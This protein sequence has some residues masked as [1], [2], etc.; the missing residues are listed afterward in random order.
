MKKLWLEATQGPWDE[1]KELVTTALE[2]GFDAVKINKGEEEKIKE[3]GDIETASQGNKADIKIKEV[4]SEEN[5]EELE[6]FDAAEI[7]VTN[8]EKE[9]L[10]G[11]AAAK[12]KTVIVV[13]EDWKVIPL[14]NLI[15]DL[16]GEGTELVAG[17]DSPEEVETAFETLE[18]GADSVLLRTEKPEDI[19]KTSGIKEKAEKEEVKLTVAEITKI[20]P[21]GMG[22]RACI[23]TANLMDKGEGMLVGNSNQGMFL[24]HSESIDTPYVDPRPFRVNAGGVHAYIRL[25]DGETEYLSEL[26]AGNSV[27]IINQEGNGKEGVVGRVKIE[28]RPLMLV[29]AETEE[30]RKASLLM[31][32]AETIRLVTPEGEPLSIAETETGNKVL[33]HIEEGGRHFGKQIDETITEK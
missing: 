33:T 10:V 21:V 12:V 17:A 23:D 7:K 3:L 27:S 14:E 5:L 9:K 29:E 2:S 4:E 15:A 25:P 16:Q 30:G 11:K 6:S 31:Q 13:A 20:E 24:V 19:K 1:R 26:E 18:H 8:K 28:K 32:N 22:D